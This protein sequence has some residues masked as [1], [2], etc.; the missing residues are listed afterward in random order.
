MP[1]KRIRHLFHAR[2]D[3]IAFDDRAAT[4]CSEVDGSA[5]QS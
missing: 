4:S 5:Q 3:W 1:E 2:L